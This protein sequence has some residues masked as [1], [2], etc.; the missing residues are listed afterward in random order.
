MVTVY[1]VSSTL[2]LALTRGLGLFGQYAYYHYRVPPGST[3][4]PLLPLFSRHTVTVGLTAWLPL[5]H[6]RS[7]E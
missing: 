1:A 7:R 5:I 3:D 6:S 2:E 4:I